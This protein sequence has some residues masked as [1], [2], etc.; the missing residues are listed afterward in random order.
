MSGSIFEIEHR[1]SGEIILRFKSPKFWGLSDSTKEHITAVQK[2]ILL[3]LRSM[4]DKAIEG[5]EESKKPKRGSK[6]KIEVQ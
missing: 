4:L 1:P 5:T 2:E 3:A 6:T